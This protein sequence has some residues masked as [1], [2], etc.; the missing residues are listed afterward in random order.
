MSQYSKHIKTLFLVL[1]SMCFLS[2]GFYKNQ[3]KVADQK[4]FIGFQRDSESMVVG[5]LVKSQRDGIFAAGGLL[6][7][8]IKEPYVS[9][10]LKEP[11][12]SSRKFEFQYEAYDK[13]SDF[14][15]YI[16]YESQIGGQGI[17]LSFLDLIM[18]RF[19]QHII[20][21]LRYAVSLFS[22][23]A[24]TF[25]II[26]FYRQMGGFVALFV[27]L[28]TLFSPWLV[29]F[30]R[31]LFWFIGGYYLPLIVFMHFLDQKAGAKPL[32][33]NNAH[34]FL[35]AF[36][37]V[38]MKCFFTGYDYLTVSLIMMMSV[39]VYYGILYQWEVKEF[40]G[41]LIAMILGSCFAFFISLI[42]LFYQ[43][44]SYSGN[45]WAGV[46]HIIYA[47]CKRTHWIDPTGYNPSKL[48]YL[49]VSCASIIS[50]YLKG[51]FGGRSSN[52]YHFIHLFAYW[53]LIVLF[54]FV[55]LV[56]F[57][58]RS[59]TDPAENR[60]IRALIGALWF[61]IL[62]PL[63]LFCIFKQHACTQTHFNFIVWHMPFMI[64]GFALCGVLIKNF[65]LDLCFLFLTNLTSWFKERIKKQLRY[66]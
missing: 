23:A 14:K 52:S 61:S 25:I 18:G 1:L 10:D 6:G 28:T 34:W 56:L 5:K 8:V 12:W 57:F 48:A 2:S 32:T 65:S 9:G 38:L 33:L 30:G 49:K 43:I 63:S 24:L 50:S 17:L 16:P 51:P 42:I 7:S 37:C 20:D 60:K 54:L 15:G 31:N 26:W 3:W 46:H 35:L 21:F 47:I 19:S 59:K 58:Y 64:Y 44:S 29:V 4:W 36:L 22:A 13:N 40:I 11:P 53:H 39:V 66:F 62:G 45:I 55:S 27:L 41:R